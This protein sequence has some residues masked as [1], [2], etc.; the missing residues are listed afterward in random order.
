MFTQLHIEYADPKN[1]DDSILIAYQLRDNPVVPRWVTKTLTAQAQYPIDAPER[2]Y[3]FGTYQEQAS[4]ALYRINQCITLLKLYD[5]TMV[6]CE[7]TD[8]RDQ[9][10]LNYLHSIFEIHHGFLQMHTSRL[11]A[12]VVMA[13]SDLNVCV[14]RCESI[15]RG[16]HP[17]HVVTYYGLP[18]TDVLQPS[19]YEYFTDIW[20]PGTVLLNYVEIGKTLDDLAVDNDSYISAAAF[21]PFSHYSADFAVRFYEQTPQQAADKHAIINAYYQNNKPMFGDWRPSYA[22]GNVP[23]A[24]MIDPLDLAAIE[25]HQYVKSVNFV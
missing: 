24:D 13:L 18:K 25:S 12:G 16:A 2:F 22:S 21:R 14:H 9:P 1:L 19:D 7:L 3:G 20:Q 11:P 10:T 4:D 8:V 23:L 6:R 15:A 17:R 5:P